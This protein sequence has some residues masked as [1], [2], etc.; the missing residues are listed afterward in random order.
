MNKDALCRAFCADVDVNPVPIGLAIRTPFTRPDGDFVSFYVRKDDLTGQV[1][2]EDDGGT[3]AFL[4]A[5]G[6]DLDSET[7]RE[8]LV[9]L[10]EEYG[11]YFDEEEVLIYTRYITEQDLP[12]ASLSFAA[13][14]LR[15][16]DILFLSS[17]RVYRSFKDDLGKLIKDNFSAE[18]T[19]EEDRYL[20]D[21]SRDY[22]ADFIVRAPSGN[23][24]AVF[25]ANSELKALEAL[26][27][28]RETRERSLSNL[29]SMIVLERSKPQAIKERTLSRVF[30]SGL[31]VATYENEQT[32]LVDKM[33]ETIGTVH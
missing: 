22:I 27:F 17:K 7:R 16:Y 26:L 32:S 3:I 2:L 18:Y 12:R 20:N 29:N 1:R 6:I 9:S 28:W 14:M 24:L 25:A 31:I 8:V 19:I 30:N 15:L 4:E 11:S 5:N 21:N 10:L 23:S 13:L 33:R